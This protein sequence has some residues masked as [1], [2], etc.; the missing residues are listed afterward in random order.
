MSG[1]NKLNYK[2]WEHKNMLTQ[3][4][5]DMGQIKTRGTQVLNNIIFM[6]G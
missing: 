1:K 3:S 2:N 5:E 4:N 6:S